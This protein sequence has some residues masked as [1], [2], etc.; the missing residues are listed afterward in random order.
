MDG[1]AMKTDRVLKIYSRLVN[2]DILRK[3]KLAQQFHVTERSVQRDMESLRCF[4]AEQGLR[5]D[6]VYD[7]AA[8]GYRLKSPA[9]ALLNNSEILAVCKILLESRSM[10]KDEMLPI[11][12]KLIACCV[13]ERSK[14]AVT[15]LLANEKY[16]YVEPHHG[17]RLLPGLWEIGQAVQ[18]HQVME[19]E[20]ERLKE[21]KLVRRRVLPV[22]IMFSEYYFYLTAFLE[23]K[24]DF[25]NPDDLFP[26]IYRI[27]RIKSFRV[28]DEHFKVPYKDRFQEGEFRKRVQFMYGGKLVKIRFKYTG[29][30]IEA[31]LDRL[32]TAEIISQ[33]ENGWTIEAEVFGK[34]IEMWLRSQGNHIKTLTERPKNKP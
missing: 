25:D 12:D 27:D 34:G 5:Q 26:T 18:N 14:R 10:R 15:E 22:G 13:P 23:D 31:V 2:G 4:F 30:S 6:I 16:H 32:P 33:D 24:T 1:T 17:Q 11:L 9:H 29:P 3:K 7:K 20:Y 19:I 8:K 28:L 21:P